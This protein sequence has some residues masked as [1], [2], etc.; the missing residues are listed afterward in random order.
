MP[1]LLVID[2][3]ASF[4]EFMTLALTL[5]GYDVQSV[6]DGETALDVLNNRALDLVLLDLSMPN[7]NGWDVLRRIREIPT[8][9]SVKVVII[10]AN[11]D[12]ETRRRSVHERID[13]LL[14]KPLSLEEIL[15]VLR[16]VLSQGP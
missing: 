3:D 5:E 4:R 12:E 9:Q 8:L 13:A 10:T 14:I 2:N 11:A 7:L 1:K 6:A 15:T 16:S